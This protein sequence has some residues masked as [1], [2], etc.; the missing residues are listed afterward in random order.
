MQFELLG[1][2]RNRPPSNNSEIA[3]A[4]QGQV[5]PAEAVA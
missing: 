1:L 5:V 2:I 4:D 3:K